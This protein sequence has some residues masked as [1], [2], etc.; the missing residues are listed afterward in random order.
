MKRAAI[1][2]IILWFFSIAWVYGAAE[3][4]VVSD[5]QV[6]SKIQLIQWDLPSSVPSLS[7]WDKRWYI[8]TVFAN[9]FDATTSK[10]RSYFILAFS[11][12]LG[13]W[14][15]HNVPK[16]NGQ[17]FKPGTIWDKGWKVW[18]GTSS[19]GHL[20]S[21]EGEAG[22][23]TGSWNAVTIKE[24]NDSPSLQ[25]DGSNT[26][27][28]RPH[29]AGPIALQAT[30][31]WKVGIGTDAPTT[32]LHV[33][34]KVSATEYCD[35]NGANCTAAADIWSGWAWG[36]TYKESWELAI[37]KWASWN[38]GL[39]KMPT[40]FWAYLVAKNANND[41]EVWERINMLNTDG[42]GARQASVYA[43][44]TSITFNMRGSYFIWDAFPWTNDKQISSWDPDWRIVFW[45]VDDTTAP[46]IS[47]WYG[48]KGSPDYQIIL[49][50][51][52]QIT[53]WICEHDIDLTDICGDGDGC[54]YR[55]LMN[56]KTEAHD[57]TRNIGWDMYF[58]D[59]LFSENNGVGL[60]WHVR[61]SGWDYTFINGTWTRTD[62]MF[63]PWGWVYFSN[64]KNAY[65]P[66]TAVNTPY[67]ASEPFKFSFMTHPYV[68]TKLMFWD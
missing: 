18:I 45:I 63:S 64:H 42:D 66:D 32:K 6:D 4:Y 67:P 30:W 26:L 22:F 8:W 29:G 9:I 59:P 33:E 49:N 55:L 27:Y 57:S 25:T 2:V 58:E 7:W 11:D 56:H 60:Y 34:G 62:H 68:Q 38:H 65:C 51:W 54:Y 40:R 17:I 10:I 52:A 21:V 35:E 16:W 46:V 31:G 1:T 53:D 50:D 61:Q 43:N 19:P 44:N 36:W 41:Y 20:L 15:N 48:W 23:L 12:I 14:N 13:S 37:A 39:W 24:Y 5:T 3:S 47:G 28:L